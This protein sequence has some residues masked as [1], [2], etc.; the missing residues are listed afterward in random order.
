MP[1]KIVKEKEGFRVCSPTHCLSKKP[2]TK[3]QATKQR[4]AVALSESRKSKKPVST[5]FA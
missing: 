1:Y 4:V 2:L 5:Y 3:K